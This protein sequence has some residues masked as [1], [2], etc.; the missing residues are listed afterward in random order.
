MPE[1][2][3]KPSHNYRSALCHFKTY[4]TTEESLTEYYAALD[5][6]KRWDDYYNN[7]RPHS[8]IKYLVPADYYR[9]NPDERIAERKEKL[10][11]AAEM[12]QS[13]WQWKEGRDQ[14][15]TLT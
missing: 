11:Q 2:R 7:K 12:R 3:D 5:A 6:M 15:Q 10:V 9:G 14:G 8:A 1:I 4:N 13:Y